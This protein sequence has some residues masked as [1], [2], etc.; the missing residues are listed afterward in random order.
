MHSRRNGFER[1]AGLTHATDSASEIE[2]FLRCRV[3]LGLVFTSKQLQGKRAV[4]ELRPPLAFVLPIADRTFTILT[5]D[6]GE[7]AFLP[8]VLKQLRQEAPHILLRALSKLRAA[9]A[10][11][12]EAGEAELA[13]RYFPD[14]HRAA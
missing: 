12:L 1:A 8:G 3:S 4:L 7:V 6:I 9:A 13:V 11:A 14:L 2:K 10:H 5:P